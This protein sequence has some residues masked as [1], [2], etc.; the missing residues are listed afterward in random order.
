VE[1]ALVTGGAGFL[2]SHVAERLLAMGP[3]VVIA[4]D[5]SGGY[6]RNVP[7]GADLRVGSIADAAFVDKLFA[8]HRIDHVFHLAAYA[9][10]VL[11]HFIRRH[12]YEVNLLGSIHLINASLR[13]EV[14]TFVFTSSIAVYGNGAGSPHQEAHA[15]TPTDPYG[16][17]KLAVEHDLRAAAEVFGLR[18]VVLR[19]HNVYGER[20]NLSDPYRNVVGIFTNQV[21]RGLPCSVFGDGSQT[22]GFSYVGDVAPRIAECIRVPAAWDETINLGSEEVVAVR[23]LAVMVQRALG[24]HTGIRFLPDRPEVRHSSADHTK[25]VRVFGARPAT[26]LVVG[27][28]RMAAWARRTEPAPLR[29]F[30]GIE[31][32]RRLPDTWAGIDRGR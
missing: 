16:V 27:L 32:K 20:Q 11:S 25:A 28:D 10:E 7:D 4:D 26:P 6:R 24:R 13:H 3:R 17:A 5:F 18:Y 8:E 19:P 21:L 31:V 2:G 9:A 29:P 14:R 30:D 1:R 23:D 15:L 22:R 12:N